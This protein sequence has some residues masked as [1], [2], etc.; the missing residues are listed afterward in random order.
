MR[1]SVAAIMADL[2]GDGCDFAITIWRI[3]KDCYLS[4]RIDAT[5]IYLVDAQLIELL[6]VSLSLFLCGVSSVSLFS[7]LRIEEAC[8]ENG[9]HK[10]TLIASSVTI[11]A[12]KKTSENEKREGGR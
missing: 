6:Y 2:N 7:V 10:N 1:R 4:S 9:L 5:R 11:I 8:P 12:S 3:T